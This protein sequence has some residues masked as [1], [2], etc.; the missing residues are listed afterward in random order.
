MPTVTQTINY[1]RQF[2]ETNFKV[3]FGTMLTL[4]ATNAI[5]SLK[6][7]FINLDSTTFFIEG[8]RDENV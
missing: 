7:N 8:N 2:R 5:A 1:F 3:A 6:V 4:I